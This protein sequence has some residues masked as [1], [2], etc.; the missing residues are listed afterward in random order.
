MGQTP[1]ITEIL[2]KT[3]SELFGLT[4]VSTGFP[5]RNNDENIKNEP[6]L[7]DSMRK[8]ATAPVLVLLMLIIAGLF[9]ILNNDGN[10]VNTPGDGDG[11]DDGNNQISDDWDVYYVDSGDDLPACGSATL[12]RLY[13][14]ASTAGFETCTSAGWAFVNLTGPAGPA[15]ADGADGAQGPAGPP[16][17][18]GADGAQGPAGADG[19]DGADGTNGTNGTQGDPGVTGADG[20]QGPPGVEGADGM[21][22]MNGMSALAVTSTEPPGTNCADGGLKIE[23]G[24]DG[25]GN[26][27]L[28]SNEVSYTEYVCNGADGA[29]GSA[30]PN[31]MLTS[32]STPTLQACSS[33]GRIIEQGL[34]NGDGGGT[35][36]NGVLEPGEVD[37]TTT[38]CSN[39]QVTALTDL[40]LPSPWYAT[41]G[42]DTDRV[43]SMAAIDDQIF[44]SGN[45]GSCSTIYAYEMSNLSAWPVG[46]CDLY[47]IEDFMAIGTRI[48][49]EG[50]LSH[51]AELWVHETINSSTWQVTDICPGSC[52]SFVYEPIIFGTRIYFGALTTSDGIELWAHETTN[53]STW[54]VADINP[55]VGYGYPSDFAIMGT[56]L[57]FEARDSSNYNLWAHETTNNSTWKVT[58]FTYTYGHMNDIAVIGSSVYFRAYDG[59]SSE[60]WVYESTNDSYWIAVDLNPTSTTNSN[61]KSFT[62][63]GSRLYF[64]GSTTSAGSEMWAFET[65]NNSAWMVAEIRSGSGGSGAG[66]YS[67]GFVEMGTRIYFSASNGSWDYELWVHDT[68]SDETWQVAE[69]NS[70]SAT[71]FGGCYNWDCIQP[72]LVVN[73]RLVFAADNGVNGNELY[74]MEIEHTI[75]YN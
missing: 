69:I 21:D 22:G 37:Y 14:V 55:G 75:T 46:S 39:Y 57:Y 61:P 48:Y 19:S 47:M 20:D 36:Q 58:A 11:T 13:Y 32:I 29:N 27:A 2:V 15:G 56:R 64:Q 8:D 31:T 70:G 41:D 33:G 49:F 44:F 26:G 10:D 17:A 5:F 18:D 3:I 66:T 30:S 45:N 9:V 62:V 53:D 50:R 38:Y 28:D 60:L 6:A 67:N 54:Q 59:T 43:L 42:V 72:L 1:T 12:G 68:S 4:K 73:D 7:L 71:A 25:N 65:T 16:G 24:L 51:G 74:M 40:N 63:I 23:V 52:S 34:D 35:S